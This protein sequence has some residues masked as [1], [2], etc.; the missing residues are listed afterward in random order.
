[1]REFVELKEKINRLLDEALGRLEPSAE[2]GGAGDW[3]PKIDLYELPDRILLR[4][5]LPGMDPADID[6]RLEDGQLVLSGR[7]RPPGDV[8]PATARRIERPFGSFL[9]RY[10]LP[11]G[12]DPEGV[13]ASYGGGVLEV[14]LRRQ[15]ET[16]VRRIP[17]QG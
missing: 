6:V 5:D 9:R 1:M 7:R 14:V 11:D 12:I 4:A 2:S 8:D 13:R 15:Q 10:A 3:S 17:V 16:S